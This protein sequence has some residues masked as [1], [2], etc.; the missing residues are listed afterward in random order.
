MK[1]IKA[2]QFINLETREVENLLYFEGDFSIV[3]ADQEY[4]KVLNFLRPESKPQEQ[5]YVDIDEDGVS[6]L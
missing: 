3:V 5:F 1:L 6:A 2:G 4:E